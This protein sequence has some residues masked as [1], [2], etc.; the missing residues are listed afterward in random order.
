MGFIKRAPPFLAVLFGGLTA[1]ALPPFHALGFLFIGF[2][3]LLLLLRSAASAKSAFRLGWLF[4]FGYFLAGLYWI[5][6]AFAFASQ[7]PEWWGIPAV[8]LLAGVLALYTG[9]ATWL[10]FRLHPP[11]WL[12]PVVLAATWTLLEWLRGHLMTGF[13]WNLAGYAW[14]SSP[15]LGQLSALGGAYALSFLTILA[16][17]GVAL[18]WPTTDGRYLRS[19]F[20]VAI[21]IA[22]MVGS[23]WLYGYQRLNTASLSAY[24]SITLRLVQGN[25][26]QAMKWHPDFRTTIVERYLQLTQQAGF[27]QVTHVIW[28][29]A[30]LPFVVGNETPELSILQ[31]GIPVDGLLL[32]GAVTQRMGAE[33]SVFANSLLSLNHDGVQRERYDK[34]HLVPFGEY[35]PLPNWLPLKKL[36]EGTQDLTPGVTA[37]PLK[38]PELPSFRSLI[39]YEV[40]FPGHVVSSSASRPDWLL[41]ISND[42]WFGKG[43]GPYQHF[44]IA[45][46]RA[47]E[48]GLTLVRVANAGIS[49]VIDPYGRIQASLGLNQVDSIDSALYRPLATPTLYS[50]TGDTPILTLCLVIIVGRLLMSRYFNRPPDSRLIVFN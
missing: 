16:G 24:P 22:F 35:V 1:L 32:T 28:P 39:C 44:A 40:I 23:A 8:L 3:G 13:P 26:P 38:L 36:T 9:M 5:S 15:E 21:M 31:V 46:L 42:A 17:S 19:Q 30:A 43:A 37:A 45:R 48:E 20:I 7:T 2:M 49:G 4:G 6:E 10:A 12:A 47:I 18:L 25:I 11:L 41:N 34:V 14:V 29:E 50:Q 27:E 33:G